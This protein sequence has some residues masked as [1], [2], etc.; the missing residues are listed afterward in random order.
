VIFGKVKKG[1]E[2]L[3]ELEAVETTSDK[4]NEDIK[5]VDCGEIVN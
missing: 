2:Y 4:P 1:L 5:V 3:D